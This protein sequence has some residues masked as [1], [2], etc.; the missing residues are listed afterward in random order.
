M[1]EPFMAPEPRSAHDE[2][3]PAHLL[4][5]GLGNPMMAD[6]GIGHEVVS[7]LVRHG[8]PEGIRAVAIDGDVFSLINEW[9][10]EPAVWFVDAVNAG[11]VPG[12]R[13]VLEH[14][15]FFAPANGGLSVHH[16]DLGESLQ[17]MRHARPEMAAIEFRLYGIEAGVV[18]PGQRLSRVVEA[19]VNRLVDEIGEASRNLVTSSVAPTM[20]RD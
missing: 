3:A 4:I 10:G 17:W 16:Q 5:V 20:R 8:L 2:Q 12:T 6:D 11:A 9:R 13:H 1:D 7:H 19:A 15:G 14:P 18:R